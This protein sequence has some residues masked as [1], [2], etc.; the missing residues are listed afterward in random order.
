MSAHTPGPWGVGG[1]STPTGMEPYCNIWGP[2]P[3]GKQSGQMI[4]A[5][6]APENAPLIAAAPDLLA[7]L[8]EMG[9][10]DCGNYADSCEEENEPRDRWCP[11]CNATDA[12]AKARGGK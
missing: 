5:E 7:A 11:Q 6:V 9:P 8:E 4:A 10:Y 3:P 1:V 2:V 12:I